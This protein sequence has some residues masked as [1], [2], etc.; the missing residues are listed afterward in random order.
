[1][2]LNKAGRWR[3]AALE[4]QRVGGPE[5]WSVHIFKRRTGDGRTDWSSEG[6]STFSLASGLEGPA[7]QRCLQ[8]LYPREHRTSEHHGHIWHDVIWFFRMGP[9]WLES[10]GLIP[11]LVYVEG[12]T[13][14]GT[15]EQ[16]K[17][18]VLFILAGPPLEIKKGLVLS[19]RPSQSNHIG[20]IISLKP[21]AGAE[22]L[23][24]H[25]FEKHS[26]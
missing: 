6:C 1:M 3:R 13:A 7:R 21:R 12:L 2:F 9:D 26:K 16:F 8:S 17:A 19:F 24:P 5:V 18:H 11:P 4:A 25:E 20:Q 23:N 14:E 22:P 10:C 15:S